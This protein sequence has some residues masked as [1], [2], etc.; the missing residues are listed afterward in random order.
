MSRVFLDTNVLVYLFDRDEPAKQARAAQLF[1]A[2]AEEGIALLSTQVLQEFYVVATGRLHSPLT[3]SEAGAAL[4][5]FAKL[6]VVTI[7]PGIVL[8]AARL[9]RSDS[10]SFWDALI[11]QAALSGGA[12]VLYSEDMQHG[13]RFGGLH[14][15]NP[16]LDEEAIGTPEGTTSR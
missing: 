14:I 2:L 6:P 5:A 13:R 10:V 8:D 3:L 9:H 11:V 16:F 12:G 1:Q 15:K 7:T 4:D